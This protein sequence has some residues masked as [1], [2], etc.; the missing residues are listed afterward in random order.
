[1][2]NKQ[3]LCCRYL[4]YL[5][6]TARF[7]FIYTMQIANIRV[8]QM[9]ILLNKH[10]SFVQFTHQQFILQM[11]MFQRL[12]IPSGCPTSFAEL[13]RKCWATEPKVGIHK[14]TL[15]CKLTACVC[16]HLKHILRKYL[17]VYLGKASVQADPLYIGVHV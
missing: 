1:M 7:H 9:S 2:M 15:A 12:T 5:Q 4:T 6:L 8:P 3:V 13:L 14:D 11:T 16:F 17:Y 10:L